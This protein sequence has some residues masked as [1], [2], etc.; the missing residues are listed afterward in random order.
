MDRVKVNSVFEFGL[1]L[2]IAPFIEDSS[3]DDDSD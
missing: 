3:Y 2:N 1:E